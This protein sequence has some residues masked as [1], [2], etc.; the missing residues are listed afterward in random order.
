MCSHL[1]FRRLTEFANYYT[2]FS[3]DSFGIFMYIDSEC[4]ISSLLIFR[5]FLSLFCFVALSWALNQ[6]LDRIGDSGHLCLVRIA[7][8]TFSPFHHDV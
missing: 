6:M 8:E 1:V 5:P 3:V 4:F 2:T 7:K